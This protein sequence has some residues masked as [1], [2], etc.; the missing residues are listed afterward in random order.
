[1]LIFQGVG[2]NK[3]FPQ[4]LVKLQPIHGKC[5]Q[6]TRVTWD[7]ECS[8]GQK[9]LQWYH[10]DEPRPTALLGFDICSPWKYDFPQRKF[11]WQPFFKGYVKLWGCKGSSIFRDV[12]KSAK[13]QSHFVDVCWSRVFPCLVFF[14]KSRNQF[15]FVLLEEVI[16][17][18]KRVRSFCQR[19]FPH[20]KR[21]RSKSSL[22]MCSCSRCLR[23]LKVLQV[24]ELILNM[25]Q[26]CLAQF[27]SITNVV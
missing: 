10:P 4:R 1:M 27:T 24:Q 12:E 18:G 15:V 17:C 13:T 19:I 2:D 11:M 16:Y 6:P 21:K 22:Q 9:Q 8:L 7:S 5:S 26:G 3:N 20:Q 25:W 14:S 23:K